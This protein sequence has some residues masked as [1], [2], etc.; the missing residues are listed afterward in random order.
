MNIIKYIAIFFF[1]LIDKFFHQRKILKELKK[2][3]INIEIFIDVGSH[4]GTYTDL[5]LKNFKTKKVFMFEPQK[6][7]FKKIKSKYFSKKKIKIFNVAVS[8]KN[9]FSEIFINE[10]DLTSSLN[11]LNNKN[12]YL[13]Y[14]SKIFGGSVNA[15]IKKSYKIK[16][17]KLSNLISKKKIKKID[18][19]KI[20]TEGHELEVL[21][22]LEKYIGL[23]RH[24]LI[25]FHNDNVYL[26]Y[27]SAKIHKYLIKNNFILKKTLKFPFTTWE[28]RIYSNKKQIFN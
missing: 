28:D 16:T 11:E 2:N 14:K 4:K 20:D 1:D 6:K 12:I 15:M 10:H 18:L 27:D 7:I 21:I 22:G 5:I 8:S 19:L 3:N 17:I 24:I 25:E 23:I 26:K 13:N 9:K